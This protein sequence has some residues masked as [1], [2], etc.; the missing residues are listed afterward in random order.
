MVELG[1]TEF[2]GHLIDGTL[3]AQAGLVQRT[4]GMGSCFVATAAVVAAIR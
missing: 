4:A 3:V 1:S 2:L